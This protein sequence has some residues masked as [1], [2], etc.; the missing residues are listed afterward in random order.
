MKSYQS[1]FYL[2]FISLIFL[3]SISKSES[4][5]SILFEILSLP[6]GSTLNEKTFNKFVEELERKGIVDDE[7]FDGFEFIG[8][9]KGFYNYIEANAARLVIELGGELDFQKK[10]NA[11]ILEKVTISKS[12]TQ[13]KFLFERFD[14]IENEEL[15]I[16]NRKHT[17]SKNYVLGLNI[18]KPIILSKT[19]ESY[20]RNSSSAY[21]A[22]IVLPFSFKRTSRLIEKIINFDKP[23]LSLRPVFG[24]KNY[25]FKKV[26]NN[27]IAD[28]FSGSDYFSIGVYDNYVFNNLDIDLVV[29]FSEN[30]N[31]T[32][33]FYIE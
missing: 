5:R 24:L 2:K 33:S 31:G 15:E 29:L 11:G 7:I 8:G 14:S 27:S 23:T 28:V 30:E 25:Y 16:L 13:N 18:S 20:D 4:P 9:P 19:T 1:F 32:W 21:G 10:Q 3:F 22:Y 26:V 6:K 17:D 12:P